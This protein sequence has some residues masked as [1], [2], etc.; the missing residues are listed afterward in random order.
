MIFS[1][2][3]VWSNLVREPWFGIGQEM[4]SCILVRLLS[5]LSKFS[6]VLSFYAIIIALSRKFFKNILK[7]FIPFDIL[8][9]G[10]GNYDN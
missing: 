8:E 10:G 2:H 3:I 1:S 7:I 4:D 9:V 6:S 5:R